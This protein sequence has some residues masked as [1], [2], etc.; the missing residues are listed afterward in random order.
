LAL[1]DLVNRDKHR[2]ILTVSAFRVGNYFV[3]VDYAPLN[4]FRP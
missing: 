1:D 4:P 3:H 2:T